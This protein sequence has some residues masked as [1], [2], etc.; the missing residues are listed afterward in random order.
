MIVNPLDQ[1][2]RKEKLSAEGTAYVEVARKNANR[3]VRF[4]NQLL[5]LR[6]IQSD[7]ASLL[8]SRVEMV[9]FVKKISDHF[10]EAARIKRIKLDIKL[11]VRKK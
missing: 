1:L 7:K 4:I 2:Y 10:T 3:M 6:K 5:D 11:Q 9:M 8:I